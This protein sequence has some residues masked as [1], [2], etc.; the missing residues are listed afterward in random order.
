MPQEPVQ[1]PPVGVRK[2]ESLRAEVQEFLSGL[3]RVLVG[4]DGD[5]VAMLWEAPAIVIGNDAVVGLDSPRRIAQMFSGAR[6]LDGGCGYAGMHPDLIDLERIGERLVIA[7][8]RWPH[9]DAA[10]REVA[11]EVSDFVLRRDDRGALKVRAMLKRER[12]LPRMIEPPL[13][14]PPS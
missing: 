9:V 10:G 1:H 14:S 12:E 5:A 8:V 2:P 3:A 4:G 7:T 13:M 6:E 11:A